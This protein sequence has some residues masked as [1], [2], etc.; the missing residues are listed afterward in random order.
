ME[1]KL[2]IIIVG[3][4]LILTKITSFQQYVNIFSTQ[5]YILELHGSHV[6]DSNRMICRV[7]KSES[8]TFTLRLLSYQGLNSIF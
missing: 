1:L 5:D 6:Y 3:T 7:K 4:K 8:E 2:C